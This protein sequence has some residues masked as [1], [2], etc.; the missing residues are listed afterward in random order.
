MATK[1][2]VYKRVLLKLSGEALALKETYQENGKTKEKVVEI[3]D[4]A[5]LT[6]IAKVVKEAVE[7]GVQVGI[8]IGAGNIWRGGRK[9][10]G[11]NRTRAD[12][13]GMLATTINCLRF[14]D[15]L[16]KEGLDARVMSAVQMPN[17][18]ELFHFKTAIRYMEKG[19]P[20][21]FAAGTGIPFVSTDTT[22]VVRGA[23]I[24]ADMIL[25]A[26]SIDGVYNRDPNKPLTDVEI[27]DGVQTVKYK[28]LS[29]EICLRDDLKAIDAAASAIAEERG[30]DTYAF[31]LEDPENIIRVL[32][33]EAIGTLITAGTLEQPEI[34]E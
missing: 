34:Y 24:D 1:N 33:G 19:C 17:F 9:G 15:A 5:K 2:P 12:H 10:E 4:P 28:K 7:M 14:Q 25:M 18:A 23:E 6:E 32:S 16:E 13:M 27:A 3:F 30:I 21:I 29:Y 8:C 22:A 20:V 26:K 11:L 31:S